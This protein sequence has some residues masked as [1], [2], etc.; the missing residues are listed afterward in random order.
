MNNSSHFKQTIGD[1]DEPEYPK[2]EPE[3]NPTTA[4]QSGKFNVKHY[5]F[6]TQKASIYAS[7]L[8]YFYY[9]A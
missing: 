8:L 3:Q 2:E 1:E 5:T 6:V 4:K 7:L 9:I